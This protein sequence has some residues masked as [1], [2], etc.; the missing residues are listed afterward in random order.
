MSKRGSMNLEYLK[1]LI[2]DVPEYILYITIAVI[3]V[4]LAVIAVLIVKKI[5]S[6]RELRIK[7][8]ISDRIESIQ[9]MD[10]FENKYTQVLEL[11][12]KYIKGDGYFLYLYEKTKNR[13]KLKRVLFEDKDM[14]MNQGGVDVSYGRI[15]PYAKESY[16]P[17]LAFPG[18]VIPKSTSLLM[19]GRFPVLVIPIKE[20]KGFISVS[21]KKKK[22]KKNS[23]YIEYMA[24]RLE[25][26]FQAFVDNRNANLAPFEKE[27]DYANETSEKDIL[28]FSLF[29]MGAKAGFFIKIENDY[30]E[31]L[32][33]SGISPDTEDRMR[34]DAS[35]LMSMQEIVNDRDH[36]IMN[37]ESEE[38]LKIPGYFTAEGYTDYIIEK[39]EKG[40]IVFCYTEAPEP[41]YLKE[42]RTEAVELLTIKMA[43]KSR[44]NRKKN[45]IE[46]YTKKLKNLARLI[47]Q[48]EPY[49]VGFS[50]L[51]SHY[52]LVLSREMK[53]SPE[54]SKNIALAA[55]LS[56]IGV[57]AIPDSILSKKGVYNKEE[58]EATQIHPEAGA[59]YVTLL[60]GNHSVEQFIRYHHERIDGLGYPE[61]L[62]GQEIP[63]GA[64]IITVVQ[65]FL[66][67]IRGRNYREP[68]SFEKIILWIEEESGKSLDAEVAFC[69]IDWFKRKQENPIYE[70]NA[71]G[72]CW[73]MRCAT[74]T[75]CSK[76][77]VYKNTSKYCWLFDSNNCLA[78]GNTCDTC[79]IYTE[80]N[81]RDIILRMNDR[82]AGV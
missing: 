30:G 26:I 65:A 57:T 47:D 8:K 43:E 74:E 2:T 12:R 55:Y 52:A 16:A 53:C 72:P 7:L 39:T 25:N 79:H 77:P 3:A 45:T 58:Y 75:I 22:Y 29:V 38:F 41:S 34:N 24:V 68:I 35:L 20:D 42:Y 56:N 46:F 50:E 63:L 82:R 31:L 9:N 6:S 62:K 54:E 33:V 4:L 81:N 51:M 78:H 73:E 48:E 32:A 76:C 66:S 18:A 13:Y 37:R 15:M 44:T 28:D 40:I 67:K 60:L 70:K 5:R 64:K 80:F 17:P 19:E 71:L 59:L 61:G 11:T 49:S 36:I 27:A 1:N 14:N 23:Q 10:D 21:I 69:L